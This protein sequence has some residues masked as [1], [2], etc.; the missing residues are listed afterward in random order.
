MNFKIGLTRGKKQYAILFYTTIYIVPQKNVNIKYLVEN[1][2]AHVSWPR[3][4]FFNKTKW[5]FKFMGPQGQ[6][7]IY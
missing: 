5:E 3:S 7:I 6:S 1:A 2:K 4:H